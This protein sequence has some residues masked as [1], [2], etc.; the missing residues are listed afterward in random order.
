MSG[1]ARPTGD[2]ESDIDDSF[3]DGPG[4]CMDADEDAGNYDAE[5]YEGYEDGDEGMEEAPTQA[6]AIRETYQ[7]ALQARMQDM[8]GAL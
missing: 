2:E 6:G 5:G 4:E 8:D 7:E 3:A 1:N